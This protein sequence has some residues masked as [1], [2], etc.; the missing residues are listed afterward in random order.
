MTENKYDYVIA[1]GGCAG[2]SLAFQFCQRQGLRDKKILIVDKVHKSKN[3]RTW[4]YWEKTPGPFESIVHRR[5]ENAWFHGPNWSKLLD[6]KPFSYKMI[7]ADR[8]YEFVRLELQKFPNI[9]FL[10]ADVEEIYSE[11]EQAILKTSKGEFRSE[12]VFSSIL[13]PVEKIPGHHYLLQHFLGWHLV[14]DQPVFQPKEPI[15]MDFRIDQQDDCRFMYILPDDDKKALVEYTLFSEKLLEMEEYKNALSSYLK[16][17]FPG[18]SFSIE[19][20]EYGVIPM[21]SAPFP[22]TNHKRIVEI[23]TAGGQTKA[24]TGYTFS[25]IQRHSIELANC[26]EKGANPKMELAKGL[27]RFIWFDNVLLHVLANKLKSGALIFQNLF[28]KNPTENVFRFLDED[29]HFLQEFRI[30]NSVPVLKFI[31]P[32]WKELLR[33]SKGK[34]YKR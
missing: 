18:V 12:W 26:L 1:G 9:Q 7:Q 20:E 4:C 19:E 3:D 34:F 23:G 15:L 17:N 28:R 8:F 21:Y 33:L 14:A 30:M 24:S 13:N 16:T 22:K 6:L 27:D 2:M 31:G 29:S 32:G 25:R 10:V 11:N 5:W